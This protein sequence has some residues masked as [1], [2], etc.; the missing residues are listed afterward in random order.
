RPKV[1]GGDALSTLWKRT[2]P[3]QEPYFRTRHT[4]ASQHTLSTLDGVLFSLDEDPK[5]FNEEMYIAMRN[6]IFELEAKSDHYTPFN[7]GRKRSLDRMAMIDEYFGHPDSLYHDHEAGHYP[8]RHAH[9]SH[10]YPYHPVSYLSHMDGPHLYRSGPSYP[11]WYDSDVHMSGPHGFHQKYPPVP[12]HL[13]HPPHPYGGHGRYPRAADW[14]SSDRPMS[15][16][17]PGSGEH[18][19]HP[20]QQHSSEASS[21]PQ[22]PL[23]HTKASPR[24]PGMA[25][26]PR[27][28]KPY[29]TDGVPVSPALA[30]HPSSPQSSPRLS[31]N[32]PPSVSREAQ[33]HHGPHPARGPVVVAGSMSTAAAA[34]AAAAAQQQLQSFHQRQH[35][36]QQRAQSD[37]SRSYHLQKH[38]R[39]L[40]QQR[41][42]KL[43]QQTQAMHMHSH[44]QRVP[45]PHAPSQSI[46]APPPV[47][48]PAPGMAQTQQ[49]HQQQQQQRMSPPSQQQQG[50]ASK[51]YQ[52]HQQMYPAKTMPPPGLLQKQQQQQQQHHQQQA[53]HIQLIRKKNAM[54]DKKTPES[55]PERMAAPVG[56]VRPTLVSSQGRPVTLPLECSNCMALDSLSWLPKSDPEDANLASTSPTSTSGGSSPISPSPSS[57]TE[58]RLLCPPCM[59]YQLSHGKSRSV[60]SYRTNFLK[61]THGRFKK[62]LQEIRFQGWQDAQSLEIVDRMTEREFNLV[63]SSTLGGKGGHRRQQSRPGSATMMSSSPMGS[64]ASSPRIMSMAPPA[65]TAMTMPVPSPEAAMII[66]IEDD[67]DDEQVK[68]VDD[69]RMEAVEEADDQEA[70]TTLMAESGTE[71]KTYGTESM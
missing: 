63:F 13:H 12:R 40:D 15:M 46:P 62:A 50:T 32:Q 34:A 47:S 68:G 60:P 23:S 58:G 45:A 57:S 59:Q 35:R 3:L 48:A 18:P 42:A 38:M 20:S 28:I 22:D 36:A 56:L 21:P 31:M 19:P 69:V 65:A 51:Q 30:Y 4:I 9:Y 6:R 41:A 33:G 37:Y 26:Q 5:E 16:L 14:E 29:P 24:A 17:Y 66:K 2:V 49:A 52:P 39:M 70:S 25:T 67:D 44:P 64:T 61:K 54:A 7:R 71:I 11:P 1:D 10:H 8:K 53:R 55:T 43:A 27:P